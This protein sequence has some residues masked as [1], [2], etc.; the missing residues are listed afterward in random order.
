MK[1][2]T[3]DRPGD[4]SSIP[5]LGYREKIDSIHSIA[6][7]LIAFNDPDRY[8]DLFLPERHVD[9]AHLDERGARMYSRLVARELAQYLEASVP[10]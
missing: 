7:A 6:P 9:H 4:P 5:N 10:R 2:G 1:M 8:P 3:M